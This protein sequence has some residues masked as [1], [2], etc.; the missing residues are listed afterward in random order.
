[1]SELLTRHPW[2][3]GIVLTLVV[4]E[5]IW[6]AQIARKGCDMRANA[7][8]L[9]FAGI[10]RATETVR[11][12]HYWGYRRDRSRFGGVITAVTL[13][14][15]AKVRTWSRH[16]AT[17]TFFSCAAPALAAPGVLTG[18][19]IVDPASGSLIGDICM[20][21][22]PSG[23]TGFSLNP[24]LNI[25]EVR[26]SLG[27]APLAFER[28]PKRPTDYDAS[29]YRLSAKAGP[30]LCISYVGRFPVY[31][32]DKGERANDDWKGR[33]AFDGKTIRA[34]DQSRFVPAPITEA[35]VEK[36][37]MAYDV[38]IVCANCRTIFWNG[39]RPAAG[40]S[41]RFTSSTPR[42]LMLYAGD[43][44]FTSQPQADFVGLPVTI[45]VATA[46]SAGLKRIAAVHASY[47]RL[48]YS[49]QPSLMSFASVGRDRK[50]D[51]TSWQF[52]VWPSIAADGRLAFAKYLRAAE[53]AN[54]LST[55]FQR[56]LAHEMAH[57][58]FG[59]RLVPNGPLQWFLT[60]STAEFL[61]MK[62]VRQ[63][64]GE[65]AYMDLLAEHTAAVGKDGAVVP[66]DRVTNADQIGETYRYKLG[67]LLLIGLEQKLGAATVSRMLSN[68]VA[69]APDTEISYA[70]LQARLRIEGA[71][72]KDLD[73]FAAECLIANVTSLCWSIRQQ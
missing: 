11:H 54:G 4:H 21:Q 70:D 68:L 40:P 8:S 50:L 23:V 60:E 20:G 2:I 14:V 51:K 52:V 33:I 5:W 42:A 18:K 64:Q 16:V 29:Y 13:I 73:V 72:Q 59:T 1:M 27:G 48:P 41:A 24:G 22:L 65:A 34:A 6:L 43:V 32:V 31:D 38:T 19:L 37:Q 44:D 26:Y 15:L 25:R 61:S 66:L 28:D 71:T 39:S 46:V 30:D 17:L 3:L 58:Y 10:R 56:Y 45:P 35:G 62:A 7:R 55:G 57:Y 9:G 69:D 53:P 63:L 36:A 12:R 47:L 67:P 49:D